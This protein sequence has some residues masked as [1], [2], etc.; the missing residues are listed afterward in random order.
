MGPDPGAWI[1][2]ITEIASIGVIVIGAALRLEYVIAKHEA[3][4]GEL[5]RRV[6]WLENKWD[7]FHAN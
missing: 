4:L 5:F 6:E 1:R 2:T 7:K 3:N